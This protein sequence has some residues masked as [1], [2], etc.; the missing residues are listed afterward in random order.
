MPKKQ[1]NFGKVAVMMGGHSAEREISLKSG[2]A[3]LKTLLDAGVDAHAF[4][5]AEQT[6]AELTEQQFDRVFIALHGRG[7]EDGTIQGA[8]EYLNIPYTGSGVLASALAMDKARC[9]QIW[10]SL[11]LKTADYFV[12]K[13]QERAFIDLNAVLIRLGASAMVKPVCEG[14]SVGMAKVTN[15]QELKQALDNAFQYDDD[16][17]VEQW[18]EGNEYTVAVLG[19]EALPS[20]CLKTPHDFYD[21]KAKYQ[22]NTTEYLCPSGLSNEQEALIQS[23][24]VKAYKAIGVSGWGRVDFMQDASGDFYLL[25]V[26]TVPGMTEKSLVPMAAKVHGLDFQALVLEILTQTMR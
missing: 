7:G 9:K 17:L 1:R 18:I 19:D 3:V 8:L 2:E 21:Y 23:I 5:T 26:N 6:L 24:A 25:E 13:K 4:D 20:I 22:S 16:V 15:E 14:S 12:A 11:T 10:Q